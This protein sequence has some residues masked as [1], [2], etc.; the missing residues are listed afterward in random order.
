MTHVSGTCSPMSPFNKLHPCGPKCKGMDRLALVYVGVSN[1]VSSG[2]PGW[3]LLV[4][5]S[6]LYIL[7][8]VPTRRLPRF[9]TR[10]TGR[11]DAESRK[12]GSKNARPEWTT[13]PHRH[14]LHIYGLTDYHFGTNAGCQP[15]CRRH[16]PRWPK[17]P[18]RTVPHRPLSL[19]LAGTGSIIQSVD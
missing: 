19:L 9:L 1:S 4:E 8:K 11:T 10:L 15:R 7:E 3:P 14:T 13:P 5:Y 2:W 16:P 17:T 18:C 12:P 6:T